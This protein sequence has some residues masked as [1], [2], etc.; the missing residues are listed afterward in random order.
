M[1]WRSRLLILAFVAGALC[2]GCMS[3]DLG[4]DVPHKPHAIGG[5]KKGGGADMDLLPAPPGM[6]TGTPK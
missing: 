3:P 5:A 6:Q 4:T 2:S 1:T